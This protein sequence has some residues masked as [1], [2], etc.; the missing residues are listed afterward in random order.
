MRL[1]LMTGFAALAIGAALASTSAFAQNVGRNA[2][3]GGLV[4][5]GDYY[6]PQ[7]S[8]QKPSRAHDFESHV[9]LLLSYAFF[10]RCLFV[11]S[12]PQRF[13]ATGSLSK[14]TEICSMPPIA[15]ARTGF[16]TSVPLEQFLDTTTAAA[17]RYSTSQTWKA[18]TCDK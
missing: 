5:Q 6:P 13:A 1:K 3:D 16:L 7:K 18:S 8:T 17:W 14:P 9:C 10:T 11:Y 2:N 15:G 12:W 4:T